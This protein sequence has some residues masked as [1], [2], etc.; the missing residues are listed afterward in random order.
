MLR[1]I[2]QIANMNPITSLARRH[3]EL[4]TAVTLLGEVA[5]SCAAV[6]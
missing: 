2:N 4:V 3:N 5:A 1:N 6:C